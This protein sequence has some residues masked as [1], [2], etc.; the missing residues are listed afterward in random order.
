MKKISIIAVLIGLVLCGCSIGKAAIPLLPVSLSD[1]SGIKLWGYGIDGKEATD[2]EYEDIIKW[3]NSINNRSYEKIALPDALKAQESQIEISLKTEKQIHIFIWKDKV[4]LDFTYLVDQP[5]LKQFLEKLYEK[6]PKSSSSS[7]AANVDTKLNT[8]INPNDIEWITKKGGLPPNNNWA[9]LFPVKDSDKIKKIADLVNTSLNY[10]KSTED[11]LLFLHTKHGYPVD[12]VIRMKDGS[13]FSL[14]PAMK[15]TTRK[16]D[17]GTETSG[18]TYK[19]RFILSYNKNSNMEYYTVFSNEVAEYLINTSN[20]DFPRVDGFS[21]T[22]EKFKLG[23]KV[24]VA[25]DGCTENEVNIYLTNGNDTDKEEY[26]IGKV[27]PIFGVWKWEGIVDKKIKTYD[28][29]DISFKHNKF[30][31][32]IQ[33]G[34]SRRICGNE[35][36]FN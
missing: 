2:T 25:G 8:F 27:K 35:I 16:V 3:V 17:N 13:E 20:S 14:K 24:V 28:G 29:K 9:V 33:V 26:I 22:P 18:T 30:M 10:R 31:I 12:I 23:D 34:D 11:D 21:I 36:S 32:G 5:E 6:A 7:N 19:D 1:V 15:L 4:L